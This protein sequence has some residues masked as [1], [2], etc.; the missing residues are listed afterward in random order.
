M[1]QT[2]DRVLG[3]RGVDDFWYPGTIRHIDG[4]RFFV[5]F[6]DG[7]D[8][9]FLAKQM[10]P[11]DF[12]VGD[13]VFARLQGR[14]YLPA[15]ITDVKDKEVRVRAA[16]GAD[17]WASFDKLRIRPDVWK[18]PGDEPQPAEPRDW[19]LGDRV[20][21]CWFDLHWYP[22]V[23]LSVE[24]NQISV[25]FDHGAP[26][27]LAA[28]RV[29]P[30]ELA[31]GDQVAGRW[32]A[33]GEFFPGQIT[34]LDGETLHIHYEDGD[35]EDTSVRL[36]RLQRDEWLPERSVHELSEGNRIF[37]RWFDGFWY[38]GI[39]LAVEGKRLHVLFDDNDQ[40]NLTWDS[41]RPLDF[42]EGDR[43]F[44]RWK[45]G[46]YYYAGEITKKDG[47]RIHIAYEDGREEWTSIRVVR[48]ENV[49]PQSASGG[50]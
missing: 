32:K 37:G 27:V 24:N 20:L 19:K 7:E 48:L 28:A 33:G 2:G 4:E 6:D 3:H 40:A 25:L 17:A 34:A 8:G 36:I 41:V 23:V 45:G 35:E 15:R 22:G 49:P 38:P 12:Q 42:D 14:E 11:P 50:G 43:V 26:A 10:M 47:E 46:P 30:L 16:N 18:V 1:W 9:F 13:R 5:I 44:G 29:R 21:A 31:V 39:I